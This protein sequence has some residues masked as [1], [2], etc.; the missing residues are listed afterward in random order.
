MV[1]SDHTD[2]SKAGT[3]WGIVLVVVG[4]V[5]QSPGLL[6]PLGWVPSAIMIIVGVL[7]MVPDFDSP[8][9]T[10][11]P[12]RTRPPM[13]KTTRQGLFALAVAVLTAGI[14]LEVFA[15]SLS[16]KRPGSSRQAHDVVHAGA[17]AARREDGA[18]NGGRI[19]GQSLARPS[20]LERDGRGAVR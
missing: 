20:L 5:L 13:K 3:V 1:P 14:V 17:E 19:E 8:S 2:K 7:L 12:K 16:Y 6:F 10:A 11:S 4:L 9:K 15:E 18:A